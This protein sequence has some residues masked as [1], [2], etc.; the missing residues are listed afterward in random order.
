M[1]GSL[2]KAF[3]RWGDDTA[4]IAR[5]VAQ[6]LDPD[7]E[8]LAAVYVQRP[9]TRSAGVQGGVNAGS[10]AAVGHDAATFSGGDER[11]VLWVD[12]AD[13][14]GI[15]PRLASRTI[16]FVVAVTTS[17]LLLVRRGYG[18]GRMRELLAAWP[19]GDLDRVAVPRGGNS[20]RIFRHGVELRCELPNEHRFIAQVYRDLPGIFSDVQAASGSEPKP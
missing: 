20:L 13:S 1:L 4:K 7:E 5:G 16:K 11:R 2:A 6:H 10:A 14:V 19:A 9:G 18:T 15:E 8:V 12:Q 3:G 17:R